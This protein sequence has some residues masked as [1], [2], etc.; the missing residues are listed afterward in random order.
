MILDI[1]RVFKIKQ[2]QNI[3]NVFGIYFG[4]DSVT[5]IALSDIIT[6]SA[7]KNFYFPMIQLFNFDPI[8][9]EELVRYGKDWFY[10]LKLP[11]LK[12]APVK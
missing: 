8:F 11:Y 12:N 5:S 1:A 6:R 3:A 7:V 10:S 2:R 9:K 4:P